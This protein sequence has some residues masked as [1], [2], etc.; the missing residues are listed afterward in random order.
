MKMNPRK[1]LL[2][3]NTCKHQHHIRFRI[4]ILIK[5]DH[6]S[7]KERF[8]EIKLNQT[9]A[10]PFA[11]VS[12]SKHSFFPSISLLILYKIRNKRS[13]SRAE[14]RREI[15]IARIL[16]MSVQ[17]SICAFSLITA[18]LAIHVHTIVYMRYAYIVMDK[19]PR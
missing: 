4:R 3:R 8:R 7:S 13:N 9:K 19:I 17:C 14:L 1:N 15:E 11:V 10:K 6:Y 12:C 5:H 16:C 18:M 2:V